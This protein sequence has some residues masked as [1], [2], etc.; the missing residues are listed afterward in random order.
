M[1]KEIDLGG[2]HIPWKGSRDKDFVANFNEIKDALS[3]NRDDN[4]RRSYGVRNNTFTFAYTMPFAALPLSNYQE[5]FDALGANTKIENVFLQ[6]IYIDAARITPLVSALEKPNSRVCRLYLTNND[7]DARGATAL[8]NLLKRE[9]CKLEVLGIGQNKF[10]NA[11]VSAISNAFYSNKSLKALGLGYSDLNK[12]GIAPLANALSGDNTHVEMLFLQGNPGLGATSSVYL[13]EM[14]AKNSKIHTLYLNDCLVKDRGA[15]SIFNSLE[16]NTGLKTLNLAGTRIGDEA[17]KSLATNLCKNTTLEDVDLSRTGITDIGAES[18]IEALETGKNTTMQSINVRGTAVTK[19][20]ANRLKKA[21][22][23]NK[24]LKSSAQ[25]DKL[26]EVGESVDKV[27]SSEDIDQAEA[28][29]RTIE[30]QLEKQS[31]VESIEKDLGGNASATQTR[32]PAQL[33]TVYSEST[34]NRVADLRKKFEGMKKESAGNRFDTALEFKSDDSEEYES[35]GK[36]SSPKNHQYVPNIVGIP[37]SGS[38]SASKSSSPNPVIGRL[39]EFEPTHLEEVRRGGV[40]KNAIKDVN[41][42]QKKADLSAAIPEIKKDGVD[43]AATKDVDV[44]ERA[45]QLYSQTP[46]A[47]VRTAGNVEDDLK[48]AEMTVKQRLAELKAKEIGNAK[49]GGRK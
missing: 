26:K 39:E 25:E 19:E 7:I 22:K 34:R 29:L 5:L 43:L 16:N 14:L 23:I 8:S 32:P 45:K 18:L 33:E 24:S 28:A 46:S 10:G 30:N 35:G 3:Q 15:T 31:F 44:E 49:S 6:G 1:S 36:R 11:G 41:I 2:K 12:T 38:I 48:G 37:L 27:L 40:D 17:A 20:V 21:L 4:G 47:S 9:D 13:A 42:E